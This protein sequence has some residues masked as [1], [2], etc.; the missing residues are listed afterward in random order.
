[1]QSL[2]CEVRVKV[3]K[4]QRMQ[5]G[6]GKQ[7][8]EDQAKQQRPEQCNEERTLL[9]QVFSFLHFDLHCR[10]P[11]EICLPEI[12]S[13]ICEIDNWLE[14]A[15][16][17]EGA[18]RSSLYTVCCMGG[19]NFLPHRHD[20]LPTLVRFTICFHPWKKKFKTY[21]ETSIE[22]YTILTCMY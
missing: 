14:E 9:G 11:R 15:D 20:I 17:K 19:Q 16:S 18:I 21:S 12:L 7:Q 10:C 5:S 4:R 2:S 6:P 13:P 8:E 22:A 1:M 3:R